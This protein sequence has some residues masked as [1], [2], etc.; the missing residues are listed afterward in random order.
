MIEICIWNICGKAPVI[1]RI[2][3][4]IKYLLQECKMHGILDLFAFAVC[5]ELMQI[6]LLL[7]LL[8]RGELL[9]YLRILRHEYQV[10][11]LPFIEHHHKFL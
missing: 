3:A 11:G 6:D 7:G 9:L 1:I 4:V 2:G 10:I 5:G 8:H